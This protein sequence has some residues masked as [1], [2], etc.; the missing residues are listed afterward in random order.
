MCDLNWC[1]VCDNAISPQS[2]NTK[3]LFLLDPLQSS[4]TMKRLYRIFC[5]AHKNVYK[6][7]HYK[8]TPTLVIS[9]LTSY[10]LSQGRAF[11]I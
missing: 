11:A 10:H 7:T 4:D 6:K 8:I 1:P 3:Y 5:I 2:V 9:T